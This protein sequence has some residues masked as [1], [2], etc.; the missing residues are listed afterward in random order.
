MPDFRQLKMY[1]QSA[2]KV[3]KTHSHSFTVWNNYSPTGH[4]EGEWLFWASLCPD[5]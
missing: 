4:W 3:R 1:T 2:R 5:Q